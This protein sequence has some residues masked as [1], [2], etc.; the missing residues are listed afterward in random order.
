MM[1]DIAEG[2][3]IS[4]CCFPSVILKQKLQKNK[5]KS[6]LH[7][8][9]TT[10]HK[11]PPPSSKGGTSLSVITVTSYQRKIWLLYLYLPS[12]PF[13]L[14]RPGCIESQFYSLPFG[15]AVASIN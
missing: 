9:P 4:K 12:A 11:Q 10:S 6:N 3:K 5:I 13:Y 14:K 15:Q 1:W 8:P 7:V 2:L